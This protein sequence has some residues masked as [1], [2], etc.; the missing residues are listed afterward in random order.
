[1]APKGWTKLILRC[2]SHYILQMILCGIFVFS[3]L[4]NIP[5]VFTAAMSSGFLCVGIA[6]SFVST[7]CGRSFKAHHTKRALAFAWCESLN[8][9]SLLISNTRQP[10]ITSE[11][12]S[13]EDTFRRC[14]QLLY[15]VTSYLN[16]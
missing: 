14:N 5:Y 1:M 6:C 13:V 12:T 8:R 9:K 7:L 16:Y 2:F 11:N 3:A 10:P 4:F 15:F